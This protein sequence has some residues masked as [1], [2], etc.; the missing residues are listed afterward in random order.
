MGT[1]RRVG[2]V[3]VTGPR[4]ILPMSTQRGRGGRPSKG[5]RVVMVTRPALPLGDVIRDR[6]AERGQTISDYIATVLAHAHGL[7]QYAPVT[8]ASADQGVLPL[9]A[10]GGERLRRSA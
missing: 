1:K 2:T 9:A 5:E 8:G 4:M 7:D 3:S 10:E 6:A